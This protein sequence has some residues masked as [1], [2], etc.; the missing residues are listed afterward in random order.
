MSSLGHAAQLDVLTRALTERW[1]QT[2]NSWRDAKAREFE[3]RFITELIAA[4]NSAS[5]SVAELER[6]LRQIRS[7]CE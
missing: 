3:D 1:R 7:D 4:V 5:R 6:I 2:R